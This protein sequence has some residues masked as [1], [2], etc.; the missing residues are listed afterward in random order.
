MISFT[1]CPLRRCPHTP[2][3]ASGNLARRTLGE[4]G[5]QLDFAPAPRHC[6][7]HETAGNCK[8]GDDHQS[9]R[10]HSGRQARNDAFA[11]IGEKDGNGEPDRHDRQR[12]ADPGKEPER[13]LGTVQLDDGAED[14]DA[15]APSVELGVRPL[16]PRVIGRLDLGDRQFELERMHAQF[17]LDLEA[18]ATI[19]R[20]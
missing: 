11:Q 19:F 8:S 9:R 15:V 6:V 13:A 16:R 1:G 12:N 5:Q 17:G 10:Q 4:I 3:A 20:A 18:G 2:V 14:A 7:E